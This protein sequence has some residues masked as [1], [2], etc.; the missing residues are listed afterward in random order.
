MFGII[1][2]TIVTVLHIYVFV[3]VA[4]VP[5]VKNRV[6]R[7]IILGTGVVL[8]LGFYAGRVFGHGATGT[9]AVILEL[10]GMT[11]MGT[12]FLIFICLF[13]ADLLTGF[14][15]LLPRCA[16]SVRGWALAVGMALSVIAL[17]QGM[18]PPRVENFDVYLSGLPHEMEDTVL[19]AMGDLH[20]G[21]LIGERWLAARIEQ[22]RHE[23]PDLVVLLGDIVEGH[24]ENHD[25]LLSVMNRL[26]APLGVWAVYGNH[27]FHRRTAGNALMDGAGFEILRNRWAEVRPGLILAGVDDL[28]TAM[29]RTGRYIDLLSRALADRPPG[30]TILL[31]HTPWGTEKA[32]DAGVGLMLC[33]HTHGG[34]IWPFRYLVQRRYPLIEGRYEVHGMTVIVSRGA[35]TWGPRMRLWSPGQI[36]R[37]TLHEKGDE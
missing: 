25:K 9:L 22:V 7:T 1:L 31:S 24:G 13:I 34:Q 14:G 30:A 15:L 37:V 35:G 27:E 33:G 16:P 21:S 12:L 6:P 32:A 17:I 23:K 3:R 36:L 29:R 28:T 20:L 10:F 11:W 18:R 26:S 8:W 4:T 19:I 2:T 5:F